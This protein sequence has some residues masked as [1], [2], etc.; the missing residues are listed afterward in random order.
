MTDIACN[1]LI[2]ALERAGSRFVSGAVRPETQCP[3]HGDRDSSLS[4]AAIKDSVLLH[5]HVQARGNS[6]NGVIVADYEVSR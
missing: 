6:K 2:W 4:T 3:Q 5:C 1:R